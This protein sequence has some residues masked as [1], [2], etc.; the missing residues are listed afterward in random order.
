MKPPHPSDHPCA[1][2]P[3]IATNEFIT[4]IHC[5]PKS[6]KTNPVNSAFLGQYFSTYL[7]ILV[8]SKHVDDVNDLS[9]ISLRYPCV[10]II[11]SHAILVR[12]H[13]QWFSR[14]SDTILQLHRVPIYQSCYIYPMPNW[15]GEW[16]D[17]FLLLFALNPNSSG[18]IRLLYHFHE[19]TTRSYLLWIEEFF[20]FIRDNWYQPHEPFRTLNLHIHMVIYLIITRCLIASIGSF[21]TFSIYHDQFHQVCRIFSTDLSQ[22]VLLLSIYH[23]STSWRTPWRIHSYHY[24]TLIFWKKTFYIST[25]FS[26]HQMDMREPYFLKTVCPQ[27]IYRRTQDLSLSWTI[28]ITKTFH[29]HTINKFLGNPNKI[30]FLISTR[31]TLWWILEAHLQSENHGKWSYSF[32][33]FMSSWN[34][35]DFVLRF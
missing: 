32:W 1:T 14:N 15:F 9:N 17:L 20:I 2:D 11:S 12:I 29:I 30:A 18:T 3:M 8:S 22:S 23:P 4:P 27:Q 28:L 33:H 19:G 16:S 26:G 24:S 5:L 31:P 34:A 13:E 25:I 7:F 6:G 35:L 10:M 21:P